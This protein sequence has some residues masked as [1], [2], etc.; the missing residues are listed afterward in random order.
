MWVM[1]KRSS[2]A[3]QM[4]RGRAAPVGISQQWESLEAVRWRHT[5]V[6]SVML[7]TSGSVSS[8][9]GS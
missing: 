9:Q 7:A 5:S 6:T 1:G 8:Q 4:G 2:A 3:L